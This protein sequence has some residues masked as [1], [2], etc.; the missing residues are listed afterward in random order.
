MRLR[1]PRCQTA[2]AVDDDARGTQQPCPACGGIL[3]VGSPASPAAAPP[4]VTAPAPVVAAA[5]P[6]PTVPAGMP[7]GLLAGVAV[8]AGAALVVVLAAVLA[9][10]VFWPRPE[11]PPAPARAPERTT[12]HQKQDDVGAGKK[13]TENRPKE[14]A[15]EKKPD[16]VAEKKTNPAA[17]LV[18]T[19]PPALTR[20]PEEMP[21]AAAIHA[22][23]GTTTVLGPGRARTLSTEAR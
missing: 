17:S 2:F 6:P 18:F 1:C 9:A 3:Q 10:V 14:Q 22:D 16:P 4:A 21:Y 19:P 5:P 23:P 11:A 12:T 13:T 15:P 8:G 7:P 20:F